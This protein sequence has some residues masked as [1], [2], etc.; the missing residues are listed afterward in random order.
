MT[1]LPKVKCLKILLII[2]NKLPHKINNPI[3]YSKVAYNK[4]KCIDNFYLIYI[5][6]VNFI[7]YFHYMFNIL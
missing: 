5:Y 6:K 4:D 3:W 1:T 2:S 7:N